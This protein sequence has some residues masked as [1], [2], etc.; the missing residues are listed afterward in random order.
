MQ[1]VGFKLH[2]LLVW[3]KN[4]ATPNRWYMKNCEYVILARKGK[5]RAIN[6]CGS[7]TVHQFDNI[8]GTKTHETEKPVEL[9]KQYIENSSHEND[10]ILDPFG[11]SGSTACAVLELGRRF[12]TIE[13][14]DKYIGNIHERL[15]TALTK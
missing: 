2:N 1:K 11:G 5:A 12:L 8:L 6:N 4:N 3:V 14:D 10:W 9:L 13:I 7:K 15:K